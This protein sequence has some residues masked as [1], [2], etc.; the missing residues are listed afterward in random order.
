MNIIHNFEDNVR[1]GYLWLSEI[2][3]KLEDPNR[4]DNAY[5][6]LKGVLHTVRDRLELHEISYISNHLPLF[7]RGV[8]FDGYDPQ[9]L[10]V[11]LYN[12][13]FLSRFRQ[14][15]GPRNS[16]FL[17]EYLRHHDVDENDPDNSDFLFALRMNLAEVE[18]IDP[19][20]AFRAVL[21][22]IFSH[23]K[24]DDIATELYR[25]M[26]LESRRD[27]LLNGSVN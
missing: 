26:R 23:T 3:E 8:F 7:I 14:R 17:E 11:M 5:V 25:M 21:E 2:A 15:M 10:S 20:T 24:P 22:V 9:H 12:D 1:E 18:D 19:A 4:L 13:E 27:N 16:E 6:V